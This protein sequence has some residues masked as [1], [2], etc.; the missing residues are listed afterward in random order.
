MSTHALLF[1]LFTLTNLVSIL[2]L[3]HHFHPLPFLTFITPTSHHHHRHSNSPSQNGPKLVSISLQNQT[4]L[5]GFEQTFH[6]NLPLAVVNTTKVATFLGIPYAQPPLGVEGRFRP[7]R[8]LVHWPAKV[9]AQEWPN[10]CWQPDQRND[11]QLRN[12]N[13]SEDCLYLNV[14]SPAVGNGS[15]PVLV[16]LHTGAFVFGSSSQAVY[17]GL[18]L[19]A[20][21]NIVVVTIN[22]RLNFFGMLHGGKT[23]ENGEFSLEKTSI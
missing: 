20:M 22:Y 7:P 18:A 17:D 14:W 21:Q 3:Y 15:Y 11:L 19:A 4:T 8:P 12:K 16:V 6:A 2:L 9:K 5:V 13:F 10:P 23:K 1:I